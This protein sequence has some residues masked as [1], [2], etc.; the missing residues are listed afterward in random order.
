MKKNKLIMNNKSLE[1]KKPK[2]MRGGSRGTSGDF[3]TTIEDIFGVVGASFN[4]IVGGID[5]AFTVL[6]LSTNMGSEW[7]NAGAPKPVAIDNTLNK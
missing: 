6:D 7:K 2:I 3:G 1:L 5:L 4:T